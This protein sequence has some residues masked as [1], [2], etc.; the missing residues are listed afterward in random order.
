MTK[1][2]FRFE[3]ALVEIEG[4]EDVL[5]SHFSHCD[6]INAY[7]GIPVVIYGEVVGIDANGRA[8]LLVKSTRSPKLM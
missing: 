1:L 3:S 6:L 5:R 7:A 2:M 8:E 4:G